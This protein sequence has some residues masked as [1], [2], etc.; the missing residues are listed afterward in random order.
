M[1]NTSRTNV[2]EGGM[3]TKADLAGSAGDAN[4]EKGPLTE[5]QTTEKTVSEHPW[6]PQGTH[7]SVRPWDTPPP[8][9]CQPDLEARSP[10]AIA[11]QMSQPD[12]SQQGPPRL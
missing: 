4:R 1:G 8:T 10:Q 3:Y 12:P 11:G 7:G 6:F 9:P 2:S 5:A